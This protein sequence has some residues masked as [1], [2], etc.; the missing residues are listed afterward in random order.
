MRA[1]WWVGVIALGW[2]AGCNGGEAPPADVD[3]GRD[4]ALPRDEPCD[5]PGALETVP[6]GLCGT[7][8][9]FC[10]AGRIWEYGL[11][12]GEHGVC[13]PGD[14][15][16][17]ACGACGTRR[18]VCTTSCTWEAV[19]ACES[20]GTC[21]PGDLVRTREGC[22][23]GQRDM[24]CSE[25]CALEPVSECVVDTCT[26]PGAIERVS[27]GMCGTRE[28]FC[29]ATGE[30]QYGLCE[31][32]GGCMPGTSEQA[33]CGACGTQTMRCSDACAWIP[34]GSCSGEGEC[35]PGTTTRRAEG[36]GSGQTRPFTCSATCS[37]EPAGAC[38]GGSSGGGARGQACDAG[39]CESGLV[40]DDATGVDIC[41]RPCATDAD[42]G[43]GSWCL[44]GSV[45]SDVCTAFLDS[46]CPT[47]AK[48]DYLGEA[49]SGPSGSMMVCSA[50]GSGRAGATC[51]SNSQCARGFS[52]V[53]D[54]STSGRCT[55]VCDA[56]HPCPTG[57]TCGSS[58]PF[59]LPGVGLGFC[60]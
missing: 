39:R 36:C 29:A 20:E 18:E 54:S 11:C 13:A 59:P 31:G 26:T 50:V 5:T 10:T 4:A 48:C 17:A 58:F 21:R 38:S 28:R 27:C 23:S 41:R 60:G 44:G 32:Q 7:V 47:G 57:Q 46:G 55:Q 37:Y 42:C 16:D 8:S 3:G 9:R 25:S 14:E 49:Q 52:C 6:C 15:R 43:S 40:C 22:A 19:G 1:W 24:R 2:V 51:T 30:W 45:C 33:A 34:F 12:E 53:Y 35:T 56:T